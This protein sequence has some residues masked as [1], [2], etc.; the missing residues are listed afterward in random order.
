MKPLFVVKLRYIWQLELIR[1]TL[2]GSCSET[3][4]KW[5]L[6]HEWVFL[7]IFIFAFCIIYL[8]FQSPKC[9]S[10]VHPILEKIHN[11]FDIPV[12]DS[13]P[14]MKYTCGQCSSA[15]NLW[16]FIFRIVMHLFYVYKMNMDKKTVEILFFVPIFP[17]HKTF[18]NDV[19]VYLMMFWHQHAPIDVF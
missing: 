13:S 5:M 19:F 14:K 2:F 18:F 8:V 6:E 15:L 1:R 12:K 7:F 9:T 10:F 3:E 11:F 16:F 17:I 4:L